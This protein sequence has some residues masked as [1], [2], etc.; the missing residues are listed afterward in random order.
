MV[1]VWVRNSKW[2]YYGILE[3]SYDLSSAFSGWQIN[4][5]EMN[6][7]SALKHELKFNK[8]LIQCTES[9]AERM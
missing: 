2:S 1:V 9:I 7:F 5:S 8:I 4:A 6:L 3:I